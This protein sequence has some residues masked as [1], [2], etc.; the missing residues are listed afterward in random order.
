MRYDRGRFTRRPPPLRPAPFVSCFASARAIIRCKVASKFCSGRLVW[1]QT[2]VD[3]LIE[4]QCLAN[5]I[6]IA[7]VLGFSVSE[8]SSARRDQDRIHASHPVNHSTARILTASRFTVQLDFKS[9]TPTITPSLAKLTNAG[10]RQE[11]K[12]ATLSRRS[13]AGSPRIIGFQSFENG[14]VFVSTDIRQRQ[15]GGGAQSA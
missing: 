13:S 6:L 7:C 10:D 4:A 2:H 11:Q 5:A 8:G 1:A 15:R 12:R 14:V 9:L 3:G